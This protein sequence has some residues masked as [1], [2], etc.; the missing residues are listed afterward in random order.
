MECG[1]GCCGADGRNFLINEEKIEK[2]NEYKDHLESEAKGVAE[3]IAKLKK[4][5]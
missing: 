3:T 2:L 1:T 5:K 4:A